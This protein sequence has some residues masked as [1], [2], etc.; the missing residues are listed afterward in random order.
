M[1]GSRRLLDY[2]SPPAVTAYFSPPVATAC[3]SPPAATAYFSPRRHEEH[4]GVTKKG[5]NE[6]WSYRVV[7]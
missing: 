6:Y 7:D 4:E 3:F 5:K 2:F 1:P